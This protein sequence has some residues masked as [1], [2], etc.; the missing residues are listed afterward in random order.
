MPPHKLLNKHFN[1]VGKKR[2]LQRFAENETF[3]HFFQPAFD[4][5]KKGFEYRGRWSEYFGNNNPIVLELGCGK[6]DYVVHL[7]RK[8]PNVNYIGV[9]IK[10]ARMW[11]GAKTAQEEQLSHLAFIRTRIENI[12]YFF[13]PGE[14][15]EIWITF[16]DPQPRKPKTQKRLTS[17]VMLN[18]YSQILHPE[19][20]IHL[21]TD[22]RLLYDFTLEVIQT[23]QHQLLEET[24][25]LYRSNIEG[26]PIEVQTFYE[27]IWLSEGLKI[28]YIT[29]QL[30][31]VTEAHATHE[32]LVLQQGS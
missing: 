24:S 22:S 9:D 6:G 11:K 15:Q 25:D 10:G 30:K 19:H 26:D 23:D 12:Q 7:A 3:D 20:I 1:I 21:K 31:S 27:N 32:R 17:P 4:E 5:L 2:K 18:R 14:V 16:P 13:A 8:H 28:N 29:F